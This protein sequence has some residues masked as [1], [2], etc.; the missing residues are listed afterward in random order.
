MRTASTSPSAKTSFKPTEGAVAD[1]VLA[2]AERVMQMSIS[3]TW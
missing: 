2:H 1:F 3:A